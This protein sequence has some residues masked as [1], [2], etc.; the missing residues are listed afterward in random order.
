MQNN[1]LSHN[2]ISLRSPTPPLDSS[3][4]DLNDLDQE[5]ARLDG[6][7]AKR[8]HFLD[9]SSVPPLDLSSIQLPIQSSAMDGLTNG[10]THTNGIA[11]VDVNG[12]GTS[13]KKHF[14]DENPIPPDYDYE[15]RHHRSLDREYDRNGRNEIYKLKD[16][17]RHSIERA[18]QQKK[19]KESNYA[20]LR[21]TETRDDRFNSIG[22]PI[23]DECL[24][25]NNG[26][27]ASERLGTK[28]DCVY[29]LLSII[30]PN[31]PVDISGKFLE[32]SKIP[33]TYSNMRGCIPWLVAA[34]HTETDEVTRSQARQA[35]HNVVYQPDDKAGRREAK[36]LRYIEQIMDYCD[37]QKR[38]NNASAHIEGD[39]HPLQA[40]SS[41]MK[42][43]F[44]NTN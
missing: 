38:N 32:L 26:T 13:T 40:M 8:P 42:V 20:L 11:K 27:G 35:L 5:L 2:I 17:R 37:S 23:H 28:V 25:K 43:S 19:P 9:Y 29:S 30:G 6:T 33:G 44:L 14:L 7:E 4:V 21:F 16:E 36:F 15:H 39:S 31:N 10:V 24:D 22:I 1:S 18:K 12:A 3:N 41:L 34:I